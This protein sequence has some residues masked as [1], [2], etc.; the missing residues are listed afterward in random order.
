MTQQD[1]GQSWRMKGSTSKAYRTGVALL[2]ALLAGCTA[3]QEIAVVTERA[4]RTDLTPPAEVFAPSAPD[5]SR[6]VAAAPTGVPG[7]GRM[8]TFD[9]PPLDYLNERY[10]L[11]VDSVWL[12][13]A[14][15]G[16]LR[17]GTGCS[18]SFV[19]FRGLVMTNHHC[20]RES[21]TK[22]TG[23]GEEL[24][25]EGF[26]AESLEDER[27]VS[28]LFV[29]Q[30][31]EVTDVTSSVHGASR[32]VRGDD[33]RIRARANR[34]AEIERQMT[35]ALA[36]GDSSLRV[37]VVALFSGGQYAAYTLRRYDDVRLVM[38][39]EKRLGYFGGDTDNFTFPRYAYDVSFFRVYDPSGQPLETTDYFR[40]STDGSAEGETVFVVGNPGATSRL[41]TVS[42]LEHERDFTLPLQIAW[43]EK[44]AQAL[45]LF[46]EDEAAGNAY[47]SLVNSLKALRGQ[48]TGLTEGPILEWRAAD[49]ARVAQAIAASDS[50][51]DTYGY[52][53]RD[54]EELQ[55]SKRAAINRNQA[56]A[57]FATPLG[58]RV[59]TRALYAY[60]YATLKRRGYTSQEEFDA[61]R[62]E[63]MSFESLPAEAEVALVTLR[64]QDLQQALGDGDASLRR[65]TG[66]APLDSV[67]AALVSST[68]LVDTLGLDSLLNLG[69]LNS[70]DPSVEV[71]NALAPLVF[72]SQGQS[73]SFDNREDLLRAR[74]AQLKFH[75]DGTETPPDAS[76]SL[77]LS[78]GVVQG[79]E[80]NGTLAPSY[81]TFYGL[82]DHYY[83]YRSVGPE[84][85]LPDRWLEI[86]DSMDLSVPLNLVSTN[87]ITGGN[88]GS[89]LL[90]ADLEIVGLIFDGNIESL[91]NVYVFS[92]DTARA[93]SVDSRGI[94]EA[95][96][97]VYG[98]DRIVNE[99]RASE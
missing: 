2:L 63:A 64:L 56:F 22:V 18:A 5:T 54:V 93:V 90:N 24:M 77:R 81:T 87:D 3:S 60:Y 97:H 92:D 38:A 8:W 20:A 15:R 51:T 23:E 28:D 75:I 79:Y 99:I 70:G 85:D 36:E 71:I 66:G 55:V 95:L 69:Y 62:K 98:T 27:R 17:F 50:L 31:I 72:T 25:D 1:L 65:I 34:A 19:S 46:L 44:R 84:W 83:A 37:Q 30:L 11:E 41:G 68:A 29:D 76:F 52:L 13:K 39:P 7:S 32:R 96:T 12:K 61:L 80:Y 9:N 49:E 57:F 35:A 73:Q 94:I 67:A 21:I 6:T 33:E 74:L 88:S 58:S 45:R 82:Y 16:A 89:P 43:L 14:M 40:W 53:F 59:L 47:F 48:L 42:T 91:P 26:Y 10:G 86:P 4:A 78:D